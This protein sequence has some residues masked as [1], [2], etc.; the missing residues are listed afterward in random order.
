MFDVMLDR[1]EA[2]FERQKRFVA[3]AGH[4]LRTP[5]SV[6]SLESERALASER[7]ADDYRQS[8][9]VVKTE[10]SYMAKLVEDLLLLAEADLGSAGRPSEVVDLGATA[11]EALD[12]LG[13]LPVSAA[14]A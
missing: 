2:A 14:S 10:C 3:D 7:R 8:L 6:I 4:E 12:A 9:S 13:L 5:L 1:L 11:L